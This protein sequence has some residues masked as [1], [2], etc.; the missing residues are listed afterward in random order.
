VI[1]M[2]REIGKKLVSLLIESPFYFKLPV[3]TRYFL[4]SKLM[5][6][7]Q[8]SLNAYDDEKSMNERSIDDCT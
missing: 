6:Q 3:K 1:T 2:K 4:L 5:V 7:L 8:N